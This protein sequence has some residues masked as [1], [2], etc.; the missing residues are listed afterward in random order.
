MERLNIMME[1]NRLC[2][3]TMNEALYTEIESL[4]IKQIKLC[5]RQL[6]DKF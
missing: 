2:V 1:E 4:S 5:G 6:N 3:H